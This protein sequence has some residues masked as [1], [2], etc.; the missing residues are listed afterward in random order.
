MIKLTR[1][2]LI[3]GAVSIASGNLF[4]STTQ[5]IIEPSATGG[6]R[7]EWGDPPGSAGSQDIEDGDVVIR[8][9]ILAVLGG[10]E[11]THQVAS[12]NEDKRDPKTVIDDVGQMATVGVGVIK[13]CG[14][15]DPWPLDGARDG[16]EEEH[17]LCRICGMDE[18][19][20]GES[21]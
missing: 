5:R 14:K 8:A 3:A 18:I 9:L 15:F 11:A 21:K 7:A 10:S 6:W 13:S 4:Q 19:A 12:P 16:H 20:H 2:Q 17:H 1:E